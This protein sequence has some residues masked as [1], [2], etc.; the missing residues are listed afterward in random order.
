M[1]R[2][3]ARRSRR[4][5]PSGAGRLPSPDA[6]LDLTFYLKRPRRR[7]PGSAADIAEL[8]HRVS[9][10]DLEAERRVAMKG[11]LGK[12]RRFAKRH[13][14]TITDEDAAR[15][16]V[17][18]RARRRDVERAFAT[19]LRLT[20]IDGRA[21]HHP[22]GRPRMPAEL[23]AHTQAVFGLDQ[24]PLR[25]RL[26]GHAGPAGDGGLLPSA[27]ASL[28]GLATAGRGA[29]QCIALVEPFGGY[30]PDDLK[31]ACA[32]M[33]LP[34]PQVV[35]I[36]VGHGR[37]AFGAD[38]EADREVSLDIQVAAAVAPE[39]RIA[40][41]FTEKS[42]AGFADGIAEAIHDKTQ[43]PDV[44]IVTWGEP[45]AFWPAGARGVV[46]GALADAVRLGVTVVVAAGD[47]LATERMND[48]RVHVDYP[49]SSPYVLAC[50]GT[51]LTLDAAGTAIADEVVW[52]DGVRGTG[53]G[54]SDIY[55]VPSYQGSVALPPSLNDGKRRR[56]VPDVA[57]A[58]AETNGYRIRLNGA[59]IVT[60]GTSAAAPLWGAFIALINEQRGQPIGFINPTLYRNPQLLKPITSG[61]NMDGGLGY[62]AGP[63]WSACTGLGSPIGA[64]SI[65]A[66]TAVA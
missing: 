21:C 42:E 58:A 41:Y 64:A 27:I 7:R 24:R 29:G 34:V 52:N 5:A 50:G 26:R 57:A 39:A 56:G 30:S 31:D 61:D 38:A 14:M 23:A 48:E 3:N 4:Q 25:S 37:N 18:L 22:T 46:D 10:A 6:R 60:G 12:I 11:T 16:R 15:C 54:I 53:G 20:E 40:I 66:L 65:A 33:S 62:K 17:R 49:A 35:E 9:R 2:K 1:A 36:D 28:Y 19:K 45:E 43:R 8:M 55:Q 44:V 51:K 32:A 13:H 59:D 63:G 47:D